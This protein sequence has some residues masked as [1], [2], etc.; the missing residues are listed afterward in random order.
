MMINNDIFISQH[1]S[2]LSKLRASGQW[3]L[4]IT[5]LIIEE[6]EQSEG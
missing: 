2:V 1:F 6:T 4:L 3:I 5:Y